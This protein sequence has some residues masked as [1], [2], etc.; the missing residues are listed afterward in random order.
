MKALTLARRLRPL[1]IAACILSGGAVLSTVGLYLWAQTDA[2]RS[3]FVEVLTTALSTPD[4]GLTI[5]AVEGEVPFAMTLTDLAVSDHKGRWLRARRVRVA[6]DA[7][8]LLFGQVDISELAIDRL[9]M[10]RPPLPRP[11]PVPEP[12]LAAAPDSSPPPVPLL[13]PLPD[14]VSVHRLVV[15]EVALGAAVLGGEPALLHV[16]GQVRLADSNRRPGAEFLLSRRDG[17]P[18]GG[19]LRIDYAPD[20]D[21]LD[22]ALSFAEPAGGVLARALALRGLPG[23]EFDAI[24]SAPLSNWRGRIT[25]RA[26]GS[27]LLIAESTIRRVRGGYLTSLTGSGNPAGLTA[28]EWA[29]AIGKEPR[30]AFEMLAGDDGIMTLRPGSSVTVAAGTLTT[31]GTL[32]PETGRLALRFK[33]TPSSKLPMAE[34]PMAA[35]LLPARSRWRSATVTGT[36]EGSPMRPT[37]NADLRAE[38]FEGGGLSARA[39]TAR[40]KAAPLGLGGSVKLSLEAGMD[41]PTGTESVITRLAGP[42]AQLALEA[43]GHPDSDEWAI[44]ALKLTLAAGKLTATGSVALGARR[45][46]ASG[47]F[48]INQLTRLLGPLGLPLGGVA[49]LDFTVKAGSTGARV[50]LSGSVGAPE[51]GI[52]A[53]DRGL[54]ALAGDNLRVKG[55]LSVDATGAIHARD[56]Q[57]DGSQL[58][59][60]A[61][62]D[63]LNRTLDASIKLQAPQLS[64]L[65]EP[66]G[67]AAL[68][69]AAGFEIHLH[70][71]ANAL[72]ATATGA[73]TD[74]SVD[75][76]T[77]GR[78][79]LE[80]RA[81]PRL[82]GMRA[83]I[84]LRA[85]T[86]VAGLEPA[87]VRTQLTI[88][89]DHKEIAFNELTVQQGNNRITGNL[90]LA[91]DGSD[92][93][94]HL[95]GQVPDLE[96]PG[97][98]FGLLL[99]GRGRFDAII[100]R[101]GER[102][103][104]TLAGSG[105]SIRTDAPVPLA[106]AE[107]DIKA[108][109]EAASTT[110]LLAGQGTGS[111]ELSVKTAKIGRFDL[112]AVTLNAE[113][114][115]DK[116]TIRLQAPDKG[117]QQ[118]SLDSAGTLER[119]T[120][121]LLLT[122]SRLAGRFGIEPL[123]LAEPT[124]LVLNRERIALSNFKLAGKT[125]TAT[126]G[127][128]IGA[129]GLKGNLEISR[130]PL[131]LLRG[132]D[133]R[134]PGKGR[135]DAKAAL[136]GTLADPRVEA[137]IRFRDARPAG[138]E[139]TGAALGALNGTLEALWR[140]GRLSL[141]GKAVSGHG[142]ADLKGRL[143]LPLVLRLNPPGPLLPDNATIK[144]SL[145]G[146]LDLSA[147]EDLPEAGGTRLGGRLNADLNLDGTVS[148]PRASGRVSLVK[149][150]YESSA[151][152]TVIE[153][154]SALL[155]ANGPDF[156]IEQFAGRA[157]NGGEV[158]VSGRIRLD[159]ETGPAFDLK[160]IARGA[161]LVRSDQ[162]SADM[163]A[164][165]TLTGSV[166]APRLAGMIKLL[167]ADLRLPD[168]LPPEVAELK[169]DE[170]RPATKPPVPGTGVS[171][172]ALPP[173]H[174]PLPPGTTVRVMIPP[175]MTKPA[176]VPFGP[177][178][179]VMAL[180]V[181]ARN[182]ILIRGRGLDGEFSCNLAI[183]GVARTPV[184]RGAL[185]M[186]RGKL[187]FLGKEFQFKRGA[188]DFSGD[189]VPELNMLA[190]ARTSTVTAT[191]EVSGNARTP[192]VTLS[193]VPPMPRD[194]I[195][196]RLL[197][198]KSPS[199]LG[200]LE[201]VQLANSAS[202]LAGIGGS[203]GVV[204][205]IRRT[206]GIDRLGVT[207]SLN[208]N[209]TRSSAVEAGRYV[210]SNVYLGVE[211]GL[212]GDS[213]RAKVEVGII[214]NVQAEIGMGMRADPQVGVKFEWDY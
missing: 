111:L 27:P 176:V 100:G 11:D 182:Q 31:E 162:A 43:T 157:P 87:L 167:R 113:G 24:G 74:L 73:L 206:L 33:M 114:T 39:L 47:H 37:I 143:E 164:D 5:G 198:D 89:P 163:D 102:F 84:T 200:A 49:D 101:H 35:G 148:A 119:R 120:E 1:L 145:S 20:T 185:T 2:G 205:R 138:P 107:L 177:P 81:T 180:N 82:S 95:A 155:V 32:D 171:L 68:K 189:E 83:T 170:P 142:E 191:V 190:E 108:T 106:A 194:E 152:G 178:G 96:G 196:A 29:P 46:R 136:T 129:A 8:A 75:G 3:R 63:I 45:L 175:A 140:G 186:L 207:G 93:S 86:G 99:H 184:V 36:V 156:T 9:D 59:A 181:S 127:G 168:S 22:V 151:T 173:R 187:D 195:M 72:E 40:L 6:I 94:G 159:A 188:I 66:L 165:L 7:V 110:A 105:N 88:P 97:R 62:A 141:D 52:E 98:L 203:A 154:I 146:T 199:Q 57:F 211:Q 161:D 26:N 14:R 126:A 41:Y 118:L 147:F 183:S 25:A 38:D 112:A 12:D 51:T 85:A 90:R 80:V 197:F 23:L 15:D 212:T 18:G 60:T 28:P 109:A 158:T 115:P 133:P 179:L 169:L 213:S 160:V 117:D 202:Q 67:L 91:A 53:F 209:G 137:S 132:L 201:A 44:T 104:V 76:R 208:R 210:A 54:E 13:L 139:G 131:E 79:E 56:W 61:R 10:T 128:V 121:G 17:Q 103:A 122:V 70:G 123:S 135:I 77:L 153:N 19:R 193:S 58:N 130:L 64:A 92:L 42:H 204:D 214:D 69:G 16:E 124:T 174:K 116:A 78:S 4:A 71:P 149:A 50:D 192:K 150:R 55:T 166:G 172:A 125:F 134:L 34:L 65:A 21:L 30:L 48:S 144:G